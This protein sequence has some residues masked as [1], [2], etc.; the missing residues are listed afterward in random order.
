M[1]ETAG[2]L[3]WAVQNSPGASLQTG[4]CQR[5][6]LFSSSFAACES[7][8]YWCNRRKILDSSLNGSISNIH[9]AENRQTLCLPYPQI[10]KWMHRRTGTGAGDEP[11][12]SRYPCEDTLYALKPVG[13]GSGQP[14]HVT[15]RCQPPTAYT[16][17]QCCLLT[18]G[19]DLC[20]AACKYS[21]TL[22]VKTTQIY[23]KSSQ[24]KKEECHHQLYRHGSFAPNT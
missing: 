17:H 19:T 15:Y 4:G 10:Q 16:Y 18:L 20:L 7:A 24:Q 5:R 9:H 6:S 3:T 1:P 2:V 8:M 13:S 14:K 21:A 11:C 22:D 23:A 12:I